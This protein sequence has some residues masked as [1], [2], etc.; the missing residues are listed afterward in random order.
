MLAKQSERSS[1]LMG[2]P[3]DYRGEQLGDLRGLLS[4]LDERAVRCAEPQ[5]CQYGGVVPGSSPDRASVRR[6]DV[7]T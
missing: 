2:V 1:V 4:V 6:T 3:K 5:E 7:R